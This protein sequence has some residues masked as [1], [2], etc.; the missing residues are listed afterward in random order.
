MKYH[1]IIGYDLTS[2]DPDEPGVWRP[3]FV[4][5][6]ATGDVLDMSSKWE[7]YNDST[8]DNI[9]LSK[10]ISVMMD[11]FIAENFSRI[12]YVEYMGEKWR[13]ESA[14]PQYPRIILTLGGVYNGKPKGT[15]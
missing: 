1:G 15:S 6:V 14:T 4:E 12:R 9:S 3:S 2:E 13:V 11:P 5:K 8:N 10:K 7:K